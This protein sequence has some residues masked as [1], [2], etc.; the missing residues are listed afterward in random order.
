MTVMVVAMAAM[1]PVTDANVMTTLLAMVMVVVMV[2][3]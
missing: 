1:L 2:A 3:A